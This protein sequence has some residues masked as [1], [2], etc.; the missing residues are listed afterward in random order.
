MNKQILVTLSLLGLS[1]S[2]ITTGSCDTPHLKENFDAVKY[3]GKWYEIYR[4]EETKFEE[5]S[6]C[7]T[8]EYSLNDDG[9]ITVHNS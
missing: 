6:E 9:T 7:D 2:K 3:M 8:A 1:L 5:N 4:E